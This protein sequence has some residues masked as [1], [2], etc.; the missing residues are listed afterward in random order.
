[1]VQLIIFTDLDGT[2]LDLKTYSYQAALPA[3]DYLREKGVPVVFCSSKTRAEQEYYRRKLR[4][5]APF[6]VENGG[7]VVIPER[8]F[9]REF[10]YQRAENSYRIIVLGV[11]YAEIRRKL[12]EI[13]TASGVNFRS[14]GD[15]T[16][17][18]VAE[19]TG[20]DIGMARLARR[21]EYSETLFLENGAGVAELSAAVSKAG[22][23]LTP[24]SRFHTV[25]GAHDKGTAVKA[26][27]ALFGE[28]RGPVTTVGIGD[29]PN[30][31]PM[32][33]DVDI[34]LL[35]QRPD[36]RWS[37][38]TVSDLQRIDGIGPEGWTKAVR[39]QVAPLIK[40]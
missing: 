4:V 22:L 1:M 38:V 33:T 34:P 19:I 2:L 23:Y 6:I 5:N 20:L 3:L 32:L 27:T 16:D 26:L 35:V 31:G 11:P 30:D 12:A 24:G 25:T 14:W 15:M 13:R 37:D 7:A 17:A 36:G 18:E 39:E 9:T 8:Y 29:G 21:R 40:T 10:P 28:S